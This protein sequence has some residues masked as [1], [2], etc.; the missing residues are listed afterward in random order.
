MVEQICEAMGT[1]VQPE[2]PNECDGGSF[3]RVRVAQ[4]SPFPYVVIGFS[5]L[6]ILRIIGSLSGMNASQM[7]ATGADASPTLIRIVKNGLRVRDH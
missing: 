2:T 5:P 3:I 4:I 6:K 1:V 7:C